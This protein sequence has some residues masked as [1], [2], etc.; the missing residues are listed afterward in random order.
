MSSTKEKIKLAALELFNE[1][2]SLSVTTNHIAKAAGI[3]PGNLYYHYR[4]KEEIIREL[5]LDMKTALNSESDFEGVIT[6]DNP[7]YSL[8]EMFV[9][10]GAIFWKYRYFRRDVTVLIRLDEELKALWTEVQN[11]KIEQ[12]YHLIKSL[13]EQGIFVEKCDADIRLE[14]K[15]S[16]FISA[17]WQAFSSTLS[18]LTPELMEEGKTIMTRL[19]VTPNLT[20]KGKKLLEECILAQQ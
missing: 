9:S 20:E 11:T 17:Y 3:S 7:V 14:A 12:I 2:D 10:H 16:W 19:V 4:N 15:H 1:G 5:F 18:E 8:F 13:T 6:S